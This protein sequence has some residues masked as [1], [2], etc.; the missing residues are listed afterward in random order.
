MDQREYGQLW[1]GAVFQYLV[2]TDLSGKEPHSQ[3]AIDRMMI[4]GSRSGVMVSTLVWNA[5]DVGFNPALGTI[6]YIGIICAAL[7]AVE[8][9][10]AVHCM[11]VEW[12]SINQSAFIQKH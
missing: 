2:Y 8:P 11:V 1:T 4:S 7:V 10:E 3:V 9:V 12:E 6:L 5:R